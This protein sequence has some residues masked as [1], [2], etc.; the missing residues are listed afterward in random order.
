MLTK[1]EKRCWC[2][3]HL[4]GGN[5]LNR[6]K[7]DAVFF[8]VANDKEHEML[9]A[10]ICYDLKKMGNHFVTECV[11]NNDKGRRWDVFDIT[12]GQVYECV[13]KHESDAQVMEYRSFGICPLFVN[14]M[15]CSVC[16]LK[17]PKRSESTVCQNCKK[18]GKK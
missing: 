11:P 2:S 6:V 5:N 14:P 18:E 9:K 13:N 12:E 10:S 4:P 15:T 1:E 8:S 16:K 3:V 7:I 17:Y